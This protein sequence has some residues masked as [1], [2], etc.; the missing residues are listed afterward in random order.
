MPWQ[1]HHLVMMI[2]RRDAGAARAAVVYRP[3]KNTGNCSLCRRAAA[4]H[5]S[6]FPRSHRPTDYRASC[7]PKC[8]GARSF[9]RTL[10]HPSS[11]PKLNYKRGLHPNCPRDFEG[12]RGLLA[13]YVSRS[14][15]RT[16][17]LNCYLVDLLGQYSEDIFHWASSSSQDSV[18]SVE[19]GNA[20]DVGIIV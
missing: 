9:R 16:M 17:L 3:R 12:F 4:Y 15:I 18:C 14:H 19:P 8:S 2:C 1:I 6:S 10:P 11:K 13:A 5:V 20:E 7:L